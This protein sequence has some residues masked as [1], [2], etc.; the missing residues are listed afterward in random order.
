[1]SALVDDRYELLDV[2]ASGGMGTVWRAR[3]TRLKRLVALK[4][5]HPAP[6]ESKLQE[7]MAREARAAAGVNH[8]N[9]VTM[10]DSGRDED[11]PYLVM[12]LVEGPTLASPGRAIGPSEA[13]AIGAQIA[14]ALAAVHEAGIVHRDVK[15]SNVILAERGPCLTDFGIAS[16]EE[17]TS[18]LTQ[19]GT[20]VA[21]PSYAAPEVLAGDPSSPASDVFSLAAVVYGLLAGKPPYQGADRTASLPVLSD[22]SID[23]VVRSGLAADPGARPSARDLAARLRASAPTQ[24]MRAADETLIMPDPRDLV[25]E[26][27]AYAT[28]TADASDTVAL[29]NLPT[30]GPELPP[31]PITRPPQAAEAV[32]DEP[33]GQWPGRLRLAA[34][35]LAV[36]V[37]AAWA[38]SSRFEP[39]GESPPTTLIASQPTT[40]VTTSTPATSAPPVETSI[41]A[42]T[43]V[44]AT[45]S[46]QATSPTPSTVAVDPVVAA[47]DRLVMVLDRIS[48]AELKPKERRDIMNRVDQAIVV[49]S[50]DPDEA[51]RALE[52]AAR[53]I[54]RE[55]SGA[56][57]QEA[58]AALAD[59]A[60]ALGL[61]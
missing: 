37:V 51:V 57:E 59:L 21:S 43:S 2:L 4:R 13:V 19:P 22:R 28:P 47:R 53:L 42:T 50:D 61:D 38:A 3:D 12:E 27:A 49:A 29:P 17:A 31:E 8:P 30:S 24:G 1:M 25:P 54:G 6:V 9:L 23:A 11:G 16:I 36:A 5:P 26:S 10:F 32:S 48:P 58:S 45:P 14:D 7:R 52:G 55:L 46:T 41:P 15:P 34:I 56:P 60:G 39:V 20:V 33:T 40:P 35:L 18:E 44:P